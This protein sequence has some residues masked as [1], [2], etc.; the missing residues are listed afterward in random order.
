MK[1]KLILYGLLA[2][3]LIG[4]V[5]YITG[6][7]AEQRFQDLTTSISRFESMDVTVLSYD[8]GWR[9]S[10]ARTRITL[11]G[12]LLKRFI[13]T[14]GEDTGAG[15][16][17]LRA[18]QPLKVIVEHQITHGPFLTKEKGNYKDWLF[19]QGFIESRLVI[20]DAAKQMLESEI[21]DKDFIVLQT[22]LNM[23]GN[24][25]VNLIGK[26]IFVKQDNIE[27]TVW[28]GIEAQWV[29]S[30]DLNNIEGVLRVPAFHFDTEK[31]EYMARDLMIRTKR[32][33]DDRKSKVW[34]A[35]DLIECE[36]ITV[37]PHHQSSVTFEQ[38]ALITQSKVEKKNQSPITQLRVA[39]VDVGPT[40]YGALRF[41][42]SILQHQPFRVK[43][44]LALDQTLLKALIPLYTALQAQS[45]D[46]DLFIQQGISNQ[47]IKIKDNMYLVDL[48]Y[49]LSE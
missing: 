2:T 31:S 8:R 37:K 35:H 11:N 32:K 10:K 46:A 5:P 22:L 6:M 20:S 41:D 25:F 36:S 27:E 33:Q 4:G 38:I 34:S 43:G 12:G 21:G 29:F 18:N 28:G 7:L 26:P 40:S 17:Q 13:E 49:Q 3:L 42:G 15:S 39:K 47:S 9:K 23:D 24:A 45:I 1:H 14:L 19:A 16:R 44:T 48:N 30:N